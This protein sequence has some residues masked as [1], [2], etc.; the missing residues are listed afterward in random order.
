MLLPM[1]ALAAGFVADPGHAYVT[2]DGKSYYLY[3]GSRLIW[4]EV[5]TAPSSENEFSCTFDDEGHVIFEG[6]YITSDGTTPVLKNDNLPSGGESPDNPAVFYTMAIPLDFTAPESLSMKATQ[7]QSDLTIDPCVITNTGTEELKLSQVE[8]S[9]ATGWTVVNASTDF[10]TADSK[11]KIAFTAG[12]HDFANGAYAP[13]EK[14]AAGGDTTLQL[15][16]KISEKADLT[17]ATQVASMVLT[18]EKAAALISFTIDGTSY[19]A[20]EGMTWGDWIDSS[21]NN[22]LFY[23]DATKNVPRKVDNDYYIAII[24]QTMALYDIIEAG[25]DYDTTTRFLVPPPM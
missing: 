1:E 5:S 9:A 15:A 3:F 25:T 21:Y 23:A 14:I 2:I 17:N 12:D 8:I 18:V 4:G 16:G 19:Q 7:G 6:K 11:N 20:E 22:G 13:N 24:D 10:T